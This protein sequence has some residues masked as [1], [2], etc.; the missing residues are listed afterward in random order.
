[1]TAH[2]SSLALA[3]RRAL[4][5]MSE[6]RRSTTVIQGDELKHGAVDQPGCTGPSA[7]WLALG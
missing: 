2:T 1:M 3:L 5:R 6:P 4:S 7:K